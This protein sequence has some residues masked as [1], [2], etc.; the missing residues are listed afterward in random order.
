MVFARKINDPL[1]SLVKKLNAATQK[2]KSLKAFVVLL[3][4]DEDAADKLKALAKKEGIKNVPLTIDNPAGPKAYK[5][6]KDADVTVLL[7]RQHTV[8]V[9][10][11]FR[12]NQFNEQAVNRVVGDLKKIL[13]Q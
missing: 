8:E 6:A 1:T 7:Y 13:S 2:N 4:K 5:I 11:A 10:H 9:N 12:G 3:S